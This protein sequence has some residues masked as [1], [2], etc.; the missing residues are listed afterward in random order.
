MKHTRLLLFVGLAVLLI[1][2]G[3]GVATWTNRPMGRVLVLQ[4]PT[5][6]VASPTVQQVSKQESTAAAPV[7]K[8]ATVMG[9]TPTA[10]STTPPNKTV[11]NCGN[12]GRMRLMVIGL[13][14]PTGEEVLG[15]DAIRLVTIDFDQPSAAVMTLPAML[16]VDMP[17]LAGQSVEKNYLTMVYAK[18][19]IAA[20][21]EPE[22]ERAQ[23]AIQA[24]AQTIV[25]NYGYVPDH[26]IAI[27]DA[28]FIKYVDILG[29]IEINLPKAVDG[30]LEG[31]GLYPAGPQKL[32]GTRTLN[33]AR[34]F[35]PGGMK[36]R[37]VWG[38]LERQNIVVKAILTAILKPQNLI[39]IPSL[40]KEARQVVITD[41]SLNQTLDLAC[42][43][44]NVGKSARM[45]AV[46]ENMVRLDGQGRMI[47]DTEAIK[48]LIADMEGGH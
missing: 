27:D 5:G 25:D 24:L 15:A 21:G 3:F 9:I 20:K 17:A 47:A 8:T 36:G 2:L 35:H 40:I 10:S 42:M 23:K 28:A 30:T 41:L 46:G 1:G 37:D 29:G 22:Q 26:Y 19:Y 14:T 18:A 34:L 13:T 45:L 43:A 7:E 16:W 48:R 12:T 32:D 4:T 39:K 11:G 38:N 31:Y 44:Q 33:F 6:V